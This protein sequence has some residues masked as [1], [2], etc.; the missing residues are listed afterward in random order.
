MSLFFNKHIAKE[1]I[2]KKSMVIFCIAV[3]VFGMV[4]PVRALTILFED[5]EDSSGFT[6]AAVGSY[7]NIAPLTGTASYPSQFRQGG[8]SQDGN[9]F[10]GSNAKEASDSPAATMT[11]VLPD[12]S[13]YTN[14]ELNVAL[15]AAEYENLDP[16]RGIFEPTHR[17]SLHIIGATTASL[18][19]LGP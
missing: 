15:A 19:D 2:M 7:W 11:I 5:F 14:L 17:D 1:P 8:S 4:E 16:D 9:I 10:Y 3:F 6:L 18:P 12:L 13:I